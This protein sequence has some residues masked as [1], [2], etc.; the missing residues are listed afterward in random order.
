LLYEAINEDVTFEDD[1]NSFIKATLKPPPVINKV[2][3]GN[4]SV[5]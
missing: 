4:I 3:L 5:K 2:G 1:V